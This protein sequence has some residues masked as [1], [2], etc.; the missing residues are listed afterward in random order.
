M[1]VLVRRSKKERGKA[2]SLLA[3]HL[4]TKK[5]VLSTRNGL[6]FILVSSDISLSILL[7]IL[8]EQFGQGAGVFGK[9]EKERHDPELQIYNHGGTKAKSNSLLHITEHILS[10]PMSTQA[11]APFIGAGY[12]LQDLPVKGEIPIIKQERNKG[13]FVLDS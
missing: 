11:K 12:I 6:L 1:S 13:Y 10:N 4:C 8:P 3:L 5:N 7:I 2:Y 9:N